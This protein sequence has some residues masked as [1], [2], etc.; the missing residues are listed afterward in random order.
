MADVQ[1]TLQVVSFSGQKTQALS[2]HVTPQP[3]LPYVGAFVYVAVSNSQGPLM[4]TAKRKDSV[5]EF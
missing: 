4:Q 1:A 2:L 3:K 5:Y